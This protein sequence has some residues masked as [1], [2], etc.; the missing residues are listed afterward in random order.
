MGGCQWATLMLGTRE[1]VLRVGGRQL[2]RVLSGLHS[3]DASPGR[4]RVSAGVVR[5]AAT[6]TSTL[7]P[8]V[9]LA[10]SGTAMS[11]AEAAYPM[12]EKVRVPSV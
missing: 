11:N 9:A 8:L 4:S 12:L 6:D 3:P 2:S 1:A 5:S 7:G 10:S